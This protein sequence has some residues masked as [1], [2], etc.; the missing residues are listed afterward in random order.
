MGKDS[1]SMYERLVRRSAEMSEQRFVLL[2]CLAA[3]FITAMIALGFL[4]LGAMGVGVGYFIT[5]SMALLYVGV[6][7]YRGKS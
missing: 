3:G 2:V 1:L 7:D 6:F 4:V 5:S